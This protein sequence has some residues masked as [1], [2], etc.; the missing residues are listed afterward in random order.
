[1]V[2][3]ESTR[4]SNF[5]TEFHVRTEQESNLA[6]CGTCQFGFMVR[7]VLEMDRKSITKEKG[8]DKSPKFNT[9]RSQRPK[10]SGEIKET[11]AGLTKRIRLFQ[12]GR[13]R[14]KWQLVF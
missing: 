11:I 2:L 7:T 13:G 4:R 5:S 6:Q 3:C 14:G 1:M 8:I 9:K 12:I 10:Q